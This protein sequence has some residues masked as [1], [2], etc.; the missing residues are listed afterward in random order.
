MIGS[1]GRRRKAGQGS[2]M[3]P[4]IHPEYMTTAVHCAC[5]ATWTTRSTK[6][7]LRLD[8]CLQLPAVRDNLD[9]R[10]ILL[11]RRLAERFPFVQIAPGGRGRFRLG[12]ERPFELT[13]VTTSY[14]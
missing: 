4:G 10:L 13:E 7:E 3:K 2:T 6:K 1:C 14:P 11:R 12:I 9:T 5:G 8:G